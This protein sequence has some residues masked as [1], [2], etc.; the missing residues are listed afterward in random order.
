M[1]FDSFNESPKPPKRPYVPPALRG[2]DSGEVSLDN[3]DLFAKYMGT[4]MEEAWASIFNTEVRGGFGDGGLD[5]A[6]G[7][8]DIPFVQVKSS[9]RGAQGFLAE[10]LRRKMNNPRFSTFIPICVGEPPKGEQ[11]KNMVM[12]SIR[13]F[14]AWLEEGMPSREEKL[15]NIAKFRQMIQQAA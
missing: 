13:E 6:T 14:G 9:W 10:A 7:D 2:N 8:P 15:N 4:D 1:K 11:A 5:V 3:T 12:E